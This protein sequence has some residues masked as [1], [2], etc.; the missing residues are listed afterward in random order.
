M[1]SDH[2]EKNEQRYFGRYLLIVRIRSKLNTLACQNRQ[3]NL[4]KTST[5]CYLGPRGPAPR[6][7]EAA[8]SIR[9]CNRPP[10]KH[11]RAR[12]QAESS[13]PHRPPPTKPATRD[14]H[15]G[16]TLRCRARPKGM[17]PGLEKSSRTK[18]KDF[19]PDNVF[20]QNNFV[21]YNVFLEMMQTPLFQIY[22][23]KTC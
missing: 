16:P 6:R 11:T 17:Y 18:C 7:C 5:L 9:R 21:N 8:S 22:H 13:I 3:V 23:F 10:R 1:V 15:R 2:E 20:S 14:K 12:L 19:Y 4:E